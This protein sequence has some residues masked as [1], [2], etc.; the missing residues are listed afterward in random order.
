MKV[1]KRLPRNAVY[2]YTTNMGDKKYH[3]KKR[4]YLVETFSDFGKKVTT[5]R[6]YKDEEL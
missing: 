4:I 5:I 2:D 1:I 6:S 3:S